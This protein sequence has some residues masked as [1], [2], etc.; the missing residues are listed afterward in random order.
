MHAPEMSPFELRYDCLTNSSL[1]AYTGYCCADAHQQ[2]QPPPK[3]VP[4]IQPPLTDHVLRL[5][6]AFNLRDAAMSLPQQ[7]EGCCMCTVD[8]L[9]MVVMYVVTTQK[10]VTLLYI[11]TC[12]VPH[13]CAH[14]LPFPHVRY[15]HT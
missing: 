8:G 6:E 5:R 1:I 12:M 2:Q 9:D 3:G 7:T 15:P 4:E 13:T 11:V 14:A 10:L